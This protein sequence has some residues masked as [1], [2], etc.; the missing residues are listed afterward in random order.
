MNC[1]NCNAVLTCG[2]QKKTGANGK[3]CCTTCIGQC[4]G[5]SLTPQPQIPQ[6]QRVVTPK[7]P[8]TPHS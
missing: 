4:N 8:Y 5:N 6:Q 1:P 2:C 3:Q 7:G